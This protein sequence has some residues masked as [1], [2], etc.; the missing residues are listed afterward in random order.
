MQDNFEKYEAEEL[1]KYKAR[2]YICWFFLGLLVT[3]V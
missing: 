1:F 3:Y 2:V